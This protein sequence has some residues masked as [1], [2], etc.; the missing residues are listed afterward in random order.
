MVTHNQ[1]ATAADAIAYLE[2]IGIGDLIR[3]ESKNDEDLVMDEILSHKIE[4]SNGTDRSRITIGTAIDYWFKATENAWAEDVPKF[5]GANV[6]GVKRELEEIG[7]KPKRTDDGASILQ[8]ACG[9]PGIRRILRETPW[10]AI[11]DEMI[12][13]IPHCSDVKG[14]SRFAGIAK[15]FREI[16]AD[17]LLEVIPF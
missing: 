15:R 13:R 11:Y 7:L 2:E 5:P 6:D 4:V 14:P 9:H 12:S 16:N 3:T 10:Q 17:E 1:S 8:V